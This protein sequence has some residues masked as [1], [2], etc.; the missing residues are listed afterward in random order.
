MTEQELR[1]IHT[2][3]ND[4][5]QFMKQFGPDV[6]DRDEYWDR[7]IAAGNEIGE[8]HNRHPLCD[9]LIVACAKYLEGLTHE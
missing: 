2:I 8:K 5:W 1:Q 9:S 7:L 3:I 4:V 6:S